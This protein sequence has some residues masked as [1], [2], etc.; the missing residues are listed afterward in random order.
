MVKLLYNLTRKEAD[1]FILV[2]LSSNLF[3]KLSRGSRGWE[4]WVANADF[5]NAL[6]LIKIYISENQHEEYSQEKLPK[7]QYVKNFSGLLAAG[8][9]SIIHIHF[10]LT[11]NYREILNK[12]GASANHIVNGELYRTVTALMLHSNAIHLVGNMASIALFG[13]IVC[14][15][16]GTGIGWLMILLSG[17]VGNY[18]NAMLY[19]SGHLAVGASTAIFGAIGILAAQNFFIQYL[20]FNMKLKS[21][22]PVA[23]G[24][25]LLGFLGVGGANTDIMAH[26]FGFISGIIIGLIYS[27]MVKK[28]IEKKYQTYCYIIFL[29]IIVI[30]WGRG[31]SQ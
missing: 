12:Y 16:N 24:L 15:L 4:I 3:Y 26:F 1:T 10:S 6:S 21:L 29:C 9:L 23:G 30:S 18:L 27:F 17:M 19:G 13:S 7:I 28:P 8:V 14:S 20:K 31:H 22:L 2:L 11:S 25:G 5:H